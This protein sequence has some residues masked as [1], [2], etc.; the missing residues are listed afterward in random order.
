M[1]KKEKASLTA[2]KKEGKDHI[3]MHKRGLYVTFRPPEW[4]LKPNP[5]TAARRMSAP[6]DSPCPV[7]H[8][9]LATPHSPLR[10]ASDVPPSSA[11]LMD[12]IPI[13]V[14]NDYHRRGSNTSLLS[15]SPPK[16][17]GFH[18][19]GASPGIGSMKR[20]QKG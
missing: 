17:P 8:M 12:N 9:S 16:S 4:R 20:W 18:L 19:R 10:R 7:V 13:P 1:K 15:A 11:P 6:E 14:V 3:A 2:T 5:K